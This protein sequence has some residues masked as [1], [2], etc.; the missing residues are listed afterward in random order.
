MCVLVMRRRRKHN[1][2]NGPLTPAEEA[3]VHGCSSGGDARNLDVRDPVWI[4]NVELQSTTGEDCR[5]DCA[6]S[7]A[8]RGVDQ[9]TVSATL[10]ASPSA[11]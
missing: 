3:R 10:A 1:D 7:R 9:I 5:R 6:V 4:G 8:L 2:A 11:A